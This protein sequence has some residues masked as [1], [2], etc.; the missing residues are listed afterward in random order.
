MLRTARI[1]GYNKHYAFFN[2]GPVWRDDP[3]MW[4]EIQRRAVQ[5]PMVYEALPPLPPDSQE[6]P[7]GT[8]FFPSAII[9]NSPATVDTRDEGCPAGAGALFSF[10]WPANGST[11]AERARGWTKVL[12]GIPG[13]P[14]PSSIVGQ[15][16]S[17]EPYVLGA[18]GAWWPP[19]VLTTSREEWAAL[20]NNRV[21]FA[22]T[23]WSDVGSGYMNGAIHNGRKHGSLVWD[24]LQKELRREAAA[25]A[26]VPI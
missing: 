7:N 3:A 22:G 1:G 24:L 19:G 25:A 10:G 8:H 14:P 20:P 15:A 26:A 11:A 17:E 21:F 5:W 16:W 2:G 4:A 13:L 9:D 18:Y 6:M 12:E 23:E